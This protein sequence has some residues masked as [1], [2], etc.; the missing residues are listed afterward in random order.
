MKIVTMLQLI[1]ITVMLAGCSQPIRVMTSYKNSAVD[2]DKFKR[3]SYECESTA[4]VMTQIRNNSSGKAITGNV[5]ANI[6]PVLYVLA[7]PFLLVDYGET[8]DFEIEKARCLSSK[9]YEPLIQFVGSK[10]KTFTDFKKAIETCNHRLNDNKLLDRLLSDDNLV[11]RLL[12]DDP[13]IDVPL[14][15][16]VDDFVWCVAQ[17]GWLI[18]MQPQPQW[19]VDGQKISK[20]PRFIPRGDWK[21]VADNADD[22]FFI[23]VQWQHKIDENI[24]RTK[25]M[26]TKKNEMNPSTSGFYVD[27]NCPN[28]TFRESKIRN[29]EN[30]PWK[31]IQPNMVAF[32][33]KNKVCGSGLH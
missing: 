29:V 21:Y 32:H 30:E 13:M 31:L 5:L 16:S 25:L 20:P 3:A 11:N 26:I 17:N 33:L 4:A 14:R 2:M 7:L 27:V 1:I 8:P 23:N 24:I 18:I 22:V 6:D 12:N 19:F 28:N 9:G 10:E 15:E